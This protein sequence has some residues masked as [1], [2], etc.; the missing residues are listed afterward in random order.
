MHSSKARSPLHDLSPTEY[1]WL[2]LIARQ[3]IPPSAEFGLPGAD[4]PAIITRVLQ[5]LDRDA[6]MFKRTI[7]NIAML[8][9]SPS[10]PPSRIDRLKGEDSAGFAVIESA[11][12]R[13]Y[14]S[15][16][17][18]MTSIG[19]EPRPPF[20]HGYTIDETTDW[21]ILEPVKRRGRA[22]RRVDE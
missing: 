12:A 2:C 22:Y 13:A 7:G 3:M 19:M 6:A 21:S 4:D 10:A 16:E 14:Y 11:V 5:L 20:P 9:G 8:A 15:D 18:V 1:D 17:R